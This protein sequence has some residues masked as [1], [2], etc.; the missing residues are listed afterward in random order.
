MLLILIVLLLVFGLGGGYY[1]HT[2]NWGYQGGI[3]IGGILL[4]ILILW[5]VFGGDGYLHTSHI[6]H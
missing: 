4:L 1:G 2:N 5:L 3:G 6:F